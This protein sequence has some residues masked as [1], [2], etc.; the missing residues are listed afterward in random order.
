MLQVFKKV[1]LTPASF[2]SSGLMPALELLSNHQDQQVSNGAKSLLEQ[3]LQKTFRCRLTAY[4]LTAT[5]NPVSVMLVYR[6]PLC[7]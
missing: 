7:L 2:Q 5:C 1:N 3:Q 4:L 6:R